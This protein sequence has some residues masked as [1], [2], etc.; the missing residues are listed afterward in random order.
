MTNKKTQY[1][2]LEGRQHKTNKIMPSLL[3]PHPTKNND[4][5]KKNESSSINK[6]AA[7][8][9]AVGACDNGARVTRSPIQGKITTAPP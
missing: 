9:A 7:A 5:K 4:S 6:R 8:A 1:H 3:H 2:P